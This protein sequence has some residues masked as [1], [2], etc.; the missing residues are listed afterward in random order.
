MFDF[1]E[2][3]TSIASTVTFLVVLNVAV[4]QGAGKWVSGQAQT[5]IAG[6]SGFC[7]GFFGG[8]A[9]FGTPSDFMGWFLNV[10]LGLVVFGVS[11]GTYEA[12][13]H[14]SNAK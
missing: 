3:L 6:V 14:A 2:W 8:L 11:V 12:V 1:A 13:K 10:I 5:I 7:L 4:V 9:S